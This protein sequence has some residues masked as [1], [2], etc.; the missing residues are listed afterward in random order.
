M[1]DAEL[2]IDEAFTDPGVAG[3]L[4]RWFDARQYFPDGAPPYSGGVLDSWPAVDVD[5]FALCYG[6]EQVIDGFLRYRKEAPS[7]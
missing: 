7:G 1:M 4:E 3:V 2:D 6:E 5:G